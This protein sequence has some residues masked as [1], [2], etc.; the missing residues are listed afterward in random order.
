[1]AKKEG[2]KSSKAGASKNTRTGYSGINIEKALVE[3]FVSLQK[4]L[5]NLSLKFDALSD[6]IAKLLEVFEI[7]AKAIAEKDFEKFGASSNKELLEKLDL[8]LDQNKTIAKGLML[9]HEKSFKEEPKPEFGLED[10][11]KSISQRE[12]SGFKPLPKY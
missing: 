1:M 6:Q 10:Y 3:N 9:M 12:V 11:K 8:L 7:S 2:K 4:V 5:T